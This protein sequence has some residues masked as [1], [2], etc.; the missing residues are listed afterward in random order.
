[1]S[2]IRVCWITNFSDTA[3]NRLDRMPGWPANNRFCVGLAHTPVSYLGGR[4][5]PAIATDA[6]LR[7][8]ADAE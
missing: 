5:A 2:R 6:G 7:F 1:M 3:S 4:Q 8:K